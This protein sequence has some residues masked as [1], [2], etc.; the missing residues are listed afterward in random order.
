MG[1]TVQ[2]KFNSPQTY[3]EEK[4]EIL[5]LFESCN[6]AVTFTPLQVSKVGSTWYVAC[7]VE[8]KAE[9]SPYIADASGAYVFAAVILTSRHN[10]EWGYKDMDECSGPNAAQAPAGL[11]RKLSPLKPDTGAEYDS[12]RYARDWRARC[13]ESA[14]KKRKRAAIKPGMTIR[15]HNVATFGGVGD[16]DTFEVIKN[17]YGRRRGIVFKAVTLGGMLCKLRA[18]TI[19]AGFDVIS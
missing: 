11:L 5:K 10:G 3:A 9:S 14:A 15:L 2:Y 19:R 7:K 13:E 1:W 16:C 8:G 18:E 4:R 12:S 17:P 6:P